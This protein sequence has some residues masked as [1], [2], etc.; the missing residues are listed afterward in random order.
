[1]FRGERKRSTIG[2]DRL[3]GK[4]Q[5]YGEIVISARPGHHTLRISSGAMRGRR[6]L[7]PTGSVTRPITGFAKKSVFGILASQTEGAVVLDIYSG[8]G[9]L[10]FEAISRGAD[11][12]YFAERNRRVTERLRRNIEELR[13]TEQTK[14]WAGNI[15]SKMALWMEKLDRVINIAFVDPPFPE[16]R[17]WDWKKVA[18]KIFRPIT[19]K[20][21]PGGVVVLRLPGNV[22]LPETIEA[23]Q[24]NRKKRYG[25]MLI[26][27]YGQMEEGNL[28]GL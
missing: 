27:F 20:L 8:T 10:G 13:V 19:E 9:T 16:T 1:M 15:D 5:N 17:K 12:V 22:P 21:A 3:K 7:P 23:L 14:V 25:D 2:V 26:G 11:F 24:C 18:E 28:Q 4:S 6:L